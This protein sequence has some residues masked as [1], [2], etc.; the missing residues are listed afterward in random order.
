MK[1]R[2]LKFIIIIFA[3]LTALIFLNFQGW[4][5]L[6]KNIF[7][8]IILSPSNF[9]LKSG[10]SLSSFFYYFI[11]AGEIKKENN[12]LFSQNLK[13]LKENAELK[14]AK[15]ENEFFKKAIAL[16]NEEKFD[17]VAAKIIGLNFLNFDNI[18]L[19]DKGKNDGIKENFSV[20]TKD[21]ILVG[22][23]IEAGSIISK[24]ATIANSAL[25]IAGMSQNSR[26]SGIVRGLG[27]QNEFLM[28]SIAK[29]AEIKAGDLVI[30]SG[31]DTIFPKN[32]LIGRIKRV[33]N[34]DNE[35]FQ[36][37]F[38]DPLVDFKNLEEVLVLK[39][40]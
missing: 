32:L 8:K 7:Y 18:I 11:N 29:N 10:R 2:P 5:E 21:K 37:A 30:T 39:S 31:I 25:N 9:F 15:N 22:K 3:L 17:L 16:K 38:I 20:I 19:I 27:S 4:L 14:E 35:F 36:R 12:N 26:A 40:Y 6:P 28:D 23:I 24:I 34:K 13:L 33:E 1:R